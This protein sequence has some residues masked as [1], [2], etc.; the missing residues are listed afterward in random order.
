MENAADEDWEVLRSLFPDG[1]NEEAART[2]AVERLRGFSSA[3]T[4][5]RTLLLHVGSGFSLR[6]TAL[7]ARLAD[8][9]HVSDVSLLKRLRNSEPWLRALCVHLMAECGVGSPSGNA[10]R[11]RIVDGTIVKEPGKTG[12]QWRILY[13]IR[14]PELECDFFEVTAAEGVGNGESLTRIPAQ[15]GELILGDAI[16]GGL[17]GVLAMKRKGADVLIRVNPTTFAAYG[18]GKRRFDLLGRVTKPTAVGKVREWKVWLRGSSGEE[19]AGRLC[20]IR[21]SEEAIRR[22]QRRLRRKESKKQTKLKPEIFEFSR[23]VMVFTTYEQGTAAQVLQWYRM[24]WQIE[25]V[26]KRLKS[27]LRLGHLPKYDARSSRAWLYGKLLIALLTQK[28]IRM[29]RDISPWG[30]VLPEF[31]GQPLA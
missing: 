2:G 30:Y 24:R 9:A 25:L 8:W 21:K 19:V 20:V 18:P 26:F 14:L 1:W 31:A 11:I 27:L 17:P 16:Y 22:A 6:E 7:R 15:N 13:T 28:L 10:P 29:G 12:S 23:Y 5:L 3:E 4:L